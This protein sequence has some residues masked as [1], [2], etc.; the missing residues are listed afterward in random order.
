VAAALGGWL[1]WV[2]S[3]LPVSGPVRWPSLRAAGAMLSALLGMALLLNLH[4]LALKLLAGGERTL[5]GAY[6]AGLILANT[7]YYLASALLAVTFTQLARVPHLK[8]TGVLAGESM[9]LM[10]VLL[11]PIEAGLALAPER[12]LGLFFPASYQPGAEALSLLAGG[13]A[14]TILLSV[15]STVYQATGLASVA[16]RV[17]L[18]SAA[19]EAVALSLVVPRWQGQGAAVLFGL[20]ALGALLALAYHYFRVVGWAVLRPALGWLARYVLALGVTA[21]VGVL[22]LRGS[23]GIWLAGGVA[24]TCYLVA[25]LVLRLTPA[26]MLRGLWPR[27]AEGR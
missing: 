7:P 1:L 4:L 14:V 2:R 19:L 25:V 13:A 3:G 12:V 6:Q 10:L 17:L 9:Q 23:A 20:G 27:A 11:L 24:G 8:H 21:A 22:A 18:A 16:G 15:L 26:G 5:V